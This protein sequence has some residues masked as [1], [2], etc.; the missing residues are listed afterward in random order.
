MTYQQAISYIYSLEEERINLGLSRIKALLKN[1]HISLDCLKVIHVGGTNGKGSVVAMISSI[2]SCAGFK[3]GVYTSPHLQDFRER[4]VIKQFEIFR[5]ISKRELIRL[6]EKIKPIAKKISRTRMG[7]PTFFEVTTAMMFAYFI[8]EKVDFA[9]LEVGLGGRL[10]A[11]NVVLPLVSVIT[12]IGL[13][14]T[15][16]LGNTLEEIAKEKCGIIKRGRI[17]IT[18]EQNPEVLK[19]IENIS[20][21][22]KARLIKVGKDVK[23]KFERFNGKLQFFK[24]RGL[25][26]RFKRLPLPLPGKHQLANASC[27]IAILEILDSLY[28]LRIKPYTIKIGLK[29]TK[30]PGRCEVISRRPLIILDGA[31]NPQASKILSYTISDYFSYKNLILILGIL[32]DKDIKGIMKELFPA[33]NFVIFISPPNPRAASPAELMKHLPLNM[34]QS[35]FVADDVSQAIKL[36]CKIASKKDLILV[37]GSLY[38]VAEAMKNLKNAFYT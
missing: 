10:D 21:S 4:I 2:L 12:N 13:E 27:A 23:Y 34:R 25:S 37:T 6:V 5:K 17:V 3:V 28:T 26:H 16:R 19:I 24:Y 31:H 18:A 30:W 29:K 32:R 8:K 15:D 20:C 14:H 35:F 7:K 1:L 9:V 38:T 11:T 36:A 22:R 33:S